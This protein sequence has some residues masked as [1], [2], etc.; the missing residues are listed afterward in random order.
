MCSQGIEVLGRGG[1]RIH[2]RVIYAEGR[3]ILA[4][5]RSYSAGDRANVVYGEVV[6]IGHTGVRRNG[7][8]MVFPD[9]LESYERALGK[10][11]SRQPCCPLGL[12][13]PLL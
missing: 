12:S 7:S 2:V 11:V 5:A 13:H 3:F 4:R 6:M 10:I 8:T 9:L 1:V